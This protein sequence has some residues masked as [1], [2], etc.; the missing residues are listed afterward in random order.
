MTFDWRTFSPIRKPSRKTAAAAITHTGHTVEPVLVH[1]RRTAH[2]ARPIRYR[3]GGG[4]H[5]PH[6]KNP[7]PVE[8]QKLAPHD[9]TTR[10][11]GDPRVRGPRPA[12]RR[13]RETRTTTGP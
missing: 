4:P 12:A 8:D 5:R 7:P 13:R 10:Q 11:P 2:S 6:T 9:N 3:S 1:G